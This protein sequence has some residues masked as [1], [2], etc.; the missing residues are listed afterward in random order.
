MSNAISCKAVQSP[1]TV[2]FTLLFRLLE[3]D[4]GYFG[5][6]VGQGPALKLFEVY[7][8]HIHIYLYKYFF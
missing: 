6:S 3:S 7:L 5:Y 2:R 1:C 8:G 4:L